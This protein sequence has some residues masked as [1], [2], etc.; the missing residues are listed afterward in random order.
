MSIK[1]S[2]ILMLSALIL[3]GC[4][5]Q[6][7]ESNSIGDSSTITQDGWETKTGST[8][9]YPS[10]TFPVLNAMIVS[11]GLQA[12]KNGEGYSFNETAETKGL[13]YLIGGVADLDNNGDGGV[14]TEPQVSGFAAPAGSKY[15]NPINSLIAMGYRVMMDADL[16]PVAIYGPNYDFDAYT[17]AQN[18]LEVRRALSIASILI[19]AAD[20]MLIDAV[21]DP[22][23]EDANVSNTNDQNEDRNESSTN[24]TENNFT[25]DN[26]ETM[27]YVYNVL[28]AEE[29]ISAGGYFDQDWGG[30]WLD[31]AAATRLL[32]QRSD[33][34]PVAADIIL[35]DT[36]MEICADLQGVYDF[37]ETSC[38]VSEEDLQKYFVGQ[39]SVS[40][41]ESGTSEESNTTDESSAPSSG[42]L[43]TM[44]LT[45]SGM[46]QQAVLFRAVS[47][48]QQSRKE[49]I[50]AALRS[51]ENATCMDL[52]VAQVL[53]KRNG[54]YRAE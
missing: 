23:I 29:C 32:E 9:I 39:S 46:M 3:A 44:V 1:C 19:L 35:Y 24:T 10:F 48:V 4:N 42:T 21:P 38:T 51:C 34:E 6:Y 22:D 50:L 41:P 26:S 13:V 2:Y 7:V 54:L 18:N 5:E 47:L 25:D 27:I 16:S 15:I 14:M 37:A 40:A 43:K 28:S 30:C 49:R 52:I 12:R 31:S 45:D 8:V 33:S 36:T 53:E 20:D 17:A 11:G